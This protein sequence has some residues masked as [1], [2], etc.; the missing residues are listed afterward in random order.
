MLILYSALQI[1]MQDA[2]LS[3]GEWPCGSWDITVALKALLIADTRLQGGDAPIYVVQIGEAEGLSQATMARLASRLRTRSSNLRGID[4]GTSRWARVSNPGARMNKL[5][6][7]PSNSISFIFKSLQPEK[8]NVDDFLAALLHWHFKQSSRRLQ[9]ENASIH[10]SLQESVDL[11]AADQGCSQ[12]W[13]RSLCAAQEAGSSCL[14]RLGHL[15]RRLL[16][17]L[18]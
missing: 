12:R 17:L 3:L 15:S 2:K 10:F 5:R 9:V 4:E 18:Q 8:E 16:G 14:L 13:D 6:T 1:R 7:M 11:C